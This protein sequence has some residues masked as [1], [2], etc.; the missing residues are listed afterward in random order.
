M[1]FRASTI[2]V[3]AERRGQNAK[4]IFPFDTQGFGYDV[5]I[6]RIFISLSSLRLYA[7]KLQLG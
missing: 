1:K 7:A 3:D 5:R 4:R 6:T 2:T